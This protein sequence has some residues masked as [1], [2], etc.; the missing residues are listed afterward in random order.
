MR[1][2]GDQDERAG[3]LGCCFFRLGRARSFWRVMRGVSRPI[4]A[5]YKQTIYRRLIFDQKIH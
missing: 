5:E 1:M 3:K 4:Y 2:N